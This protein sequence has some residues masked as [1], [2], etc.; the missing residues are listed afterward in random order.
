MKD[1]DLELLKKSI[2]KL[3]LI[4]DVLHTNKHEQAGSLS[5]SINMLESIVIDEEEERS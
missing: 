2:K 4:E 5:A 1:V 3:E